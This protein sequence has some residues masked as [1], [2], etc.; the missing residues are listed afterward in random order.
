MS[1]ESDTVSGWFILTAGFKVYGRCP[2]CGSHRIAYYKSRRPGLKGISA[3]SQ[4]LTPA[5]TDCGKSL[6]NQV[7]KEKKYPALIIRAKC[8]S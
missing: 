8:A 7:E 1:S 6:P 3:A 4:G 5:C 2:A